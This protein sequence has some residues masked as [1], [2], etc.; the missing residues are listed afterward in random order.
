MMFHLI[1]S[2]LR[3]ILKIAQNFL[4]HEP[5]V[6]IFFQNEAEMNEKM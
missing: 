3:R 2:Q 6:T 4:K 1:T 5:D